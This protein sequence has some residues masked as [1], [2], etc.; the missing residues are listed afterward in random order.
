[1]MV[2]VLLAAGASKRMGRTKALAKV[3]SESYVARGIRNLWCACDKV[4]VVL[5]ADAARIRKHTEEE[6]VRLVETGCLDQAL[7]AAL[8]RK[9][10]ELEVRFV[11]NRAWK[12]GMYSSVRAGL[13]AAVKLG[14][15]AVVVMPVDHPAVRPGTVLDLAVVMAQ[16]V[17]AARG[18][19]GRK[20]SPART[21]FSYALIPRYRGRRGHPI[22]LSATLARAVAKDASAAHLSDAVRRNARLVGYLDVRDPGVTRNVN[23]PGD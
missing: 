4:V 21:R 7:H 16:A 23:R 13:A 19:K 8:R 3:G 2:G 5:G 22:V 12:R 11:V 6:F 15:D 10:Q 1:M 18:R 9:V 14:R 20:G 17:S